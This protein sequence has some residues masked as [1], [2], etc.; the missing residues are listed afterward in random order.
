MPDD[1]LRIPPAIPR[2]F[3]T[4]LF[5]LGVVLFVGWGLMYGVWLDVGLYAIC[6]VII[7]FGITGMY[8]YSQIEKEAQETEKD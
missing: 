2:I 8:L 6:A 5:V 1:D 7:G 3:Y 4:I